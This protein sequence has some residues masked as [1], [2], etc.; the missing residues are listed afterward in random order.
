MNDPRLVQVAASIDERGE[1][2]PQH[3]PLAVHHA[4]AS[5]GI[6]P[7]ARDSYRGGAYAGCDRDPLGHAECA[8]RRRQR[9]RIL[10]D[11]ESLVI[12]KR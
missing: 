5:I 4:I 2:D 8:L 3:P 11:G 6:A 1:D 7:T 12:D 9:P 10:D